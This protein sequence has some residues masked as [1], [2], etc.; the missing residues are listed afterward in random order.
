M[1]GM[2]KRVTRGRSAFARSADGHAD[3]CKQR[4]RHA[5]L[6]G[7]AHGNDATAMIPATEMSISGR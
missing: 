7:E 4:R 5:M 3:D 2:A 6:I 1:E